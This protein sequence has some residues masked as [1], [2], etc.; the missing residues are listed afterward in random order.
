VVRIDQPGRLLILD[1]LA[2]HHLDRL[3]H[4][5]DGRVGAGGGTG[6]R[7]AIAVDRPVRD[8]AAAGGAGHLNRRQVDRRGRGRQCLGQDI[9][10]RQAEADP[11]QEGKT[12]TGDGGVGRR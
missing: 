10:Q 7:C 11:A 3:R 1:H 8:L 2:R 5:L 6:P 9:G 12:P 4:V